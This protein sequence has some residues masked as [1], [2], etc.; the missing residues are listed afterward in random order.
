MLLGI[1][2]CSGDEREAAGCLYVS[3]CGRG[4]GRNGRVQGEEKRRLAKLK[5]GRFIPHNISKGEKQ[6]SDT[7]NSLHNCSCSL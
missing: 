5:K 7:V 1:R 3:V 2:D 6:Y 4:G